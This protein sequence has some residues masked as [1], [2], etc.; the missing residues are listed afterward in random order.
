MHRCVR[1]KKITTRRSKT[2][3]SVAAATLAQAFKVDFQFPLLILIPSYTHTIISQYIG[4]YGNII[5]NFSVQQDFINTLLYLYSWDFYC[6]NSRL[7]IG[8]T[9]KCSNK[10]RCPLVQPSQKERP[11]EYQITTKASE[12][13]T[14][15]SSLSSITDSCGIVPFFTRSPDTASTISSSTSTSATR[16]TSRCA[17]ANCRFSGS[18]HIICYSSRTNKHCNPSRY[19]IVHK[20]ITDGFIFQFIIIFIISQLTS[21]HRQLQPINLWYQWHQPARGA[22]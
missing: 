9:Q 8:K 13:N 10:C 5:G 17:W 4:C 14:T 18:D 22:K 16:S 6:C 2:S 7:Q 20:I 1:F 11:Q 21:F 3:P 19:S 12:D 15:L